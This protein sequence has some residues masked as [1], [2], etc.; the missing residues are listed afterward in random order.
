ML[1]LNMGGVDWVRAVRRPATAK[2]AAGALVALSD[3]LS[4]DASYEIWQAA[5][6]VSLYDNMRMRERSLI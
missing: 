3:D 4:G 1:D 2:C 6:N 5:A